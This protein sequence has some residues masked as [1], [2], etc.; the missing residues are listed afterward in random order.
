MADIS[1]ADSRHAR[2]QLNAG[3][4]GLSLTGRW[5]VRDGIYNRNAIYWF[6]H[7]QDRC[8]YDVIAASGTSIKEWVHLLRKT[9]F[10]VCTVKQR[11]REEQHCDDAYQVR[12]AGTGVVK[13]LRIL[14]EGD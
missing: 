5:K 2:K 3:T 8:W 10:C 4:H 14:R 13:P 9:G 11:G 6:W 1:Q 12:G 7:P